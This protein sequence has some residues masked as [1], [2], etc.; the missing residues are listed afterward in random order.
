MKKT[1]F[2]L[3]ELMIVLALIGIL[4]MISYPLYSEHIIR[5]RR[6]YIATVLVD[7]ASSMERY[8]LLNNSYNDATLE[9]LSVTDESYKDSYHLDIKAKEENYILRA[10]PIGK[11]ATD[12]SCGEL[13][14]D[15]NGNKSI[16][17]SETAAKCWR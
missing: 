6:V 8:Y 9:K 3:I 17:G 1:G 12:F 7:L 16:S 4:S 2:T 14:L 11:Q 13:I 15:Q 5:A 10:I